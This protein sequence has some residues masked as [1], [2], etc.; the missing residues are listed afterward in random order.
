MCE[1]LCVAMFYCIL[2]YGVQFQLGFEIFMILAQQVKRIKY[3]EQN[4]INKFYDAKTTQTNM[5]I[6]VINKITTKC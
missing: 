5:R 1:C 6:F 4:T 2:F 3:K